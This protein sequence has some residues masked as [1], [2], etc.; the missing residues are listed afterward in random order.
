MGNSNHGHNESGYD[1]WKWKLE[2]GKRRA[3]NESHDDGDTN[4]DDEESCSSLPK[5]ETR[6]KYRV[7]NSFSCNVG[8]FSN[9][10]VAKQTES[11]GVSSG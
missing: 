11:F 3:V 5:Q 8:R 4:G 7:E 2:D 6:N 1:C 10:V 9:R